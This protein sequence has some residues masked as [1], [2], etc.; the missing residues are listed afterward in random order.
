MANVHTFTRKEEM[1]NASIHAIGVLFSI[2]ALVILLIHAGT[3]APVISVSIYGSTMLFLYMS[4]TLVHFVKEGKAKDIFEIFDHAAIYLFI[5]GTY[6]PLLFHALDGALSWT[7]F[8]IVWGIAV[9]GVIFKIFFVKRFLFLSTIFYIGMGW[10]IVFAWVPLSENLPGGGL[11]LLI[12]GGILY[13]AGSVFYVWRR[14]PYH[15]GIWHVF[16][17]VASFLH[18]L[19]ILLYVLP[20]MN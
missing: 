1:V 12:A 6:T 2:A 8:G 3:P 20:L 4:S 17:L 13:T 19:A 14:I 9:L 15:H 11:N 16:V 18:F 7:L 10:I 5:A